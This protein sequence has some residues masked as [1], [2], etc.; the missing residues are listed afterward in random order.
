MSEPESP[1]PQP[2]RP[3][4]AGVIAPPPL[5]FLAALIL[6]WLLDRVVPLPVL[7]AG[8]APWLGGALAL[9]AIAIGVSAVREMRRAR[10][11][12]DPYRPTTA[13]VLTGPFAR[14]RNPIYVGLTTLALG[15]SLLANTLWCLLLLV[16]AVLA[17]RYGVI[18]R[19]EAYLER[20]F[21][22]AYRAYCDTTPRWI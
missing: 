10:T 20:R 16:P 9:G 22:Q 13:L 2:A 7:P 6:G 11:A 21:G 17:V 19:E 5:I 14:S 1:T 4:T 8:L 3:D 18:A 15:L 12:I